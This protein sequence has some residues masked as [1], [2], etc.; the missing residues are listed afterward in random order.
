MYNAPYKVLDWNDDKPF[1][2]SSAF[3]VMTFYLN[4]MKKTNAL[5]KKMITY[6][7]HLGS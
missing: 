4:N 5:K 3:F 1:F 2:C 6:M 7:K